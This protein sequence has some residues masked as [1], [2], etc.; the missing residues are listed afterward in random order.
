MS[1]NALEIL[2]PIP[3]VNTKGTYNDYTAAEICRRIAEGESLTAICKNTD[4]IP[5]RCTI[6]HWIA[7]VPH[8]AAAYA[9]ARLIQ[10]DTFADQIV[11]IADNVALLPDHKRLMIDSRK[12]RA[13]RQNWR[14]WG[15]K[16]QHEHHADLGAPAGSSLLPPG[17]EFLAGKLPSDEPEEQPGSDTGGVGP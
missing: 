15:D 11:D 4:H 16:V 10:A 13:G 6:H 5:D 14:A 3:R 9:R 17:L 2:G 8:F 7:N 12:W 1:T